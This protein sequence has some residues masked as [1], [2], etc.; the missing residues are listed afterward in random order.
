MLYLIGTGASHLHFQV[1][2]L[3]LINR[4]FQLFD[5]VRDPGGNVGIDDGKDEQHKCDDEHHQEL[6]LDVVKGH[7]VKGR[8]AHNLPP[9]IS[10]G[11]H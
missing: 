7:A 4:L 5:R 10:H 1:P 11:L 6:C 8:D 2:L 3:N 9:R